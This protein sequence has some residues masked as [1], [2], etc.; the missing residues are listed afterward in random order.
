M[1]IIKKK[2]PGFFKEYKTIKAY[3]DYLK[4]EYGVDNSDNLLVV[5]KK[6]NIVPY[7]KLFIYVFTKA[8]RFIINILLFIFAAIG[9]IALL[10]PSIGCL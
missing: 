5:E 8:V 3:K 1:I 4:K 6:N 2:K 9:M 10:Y 7:I